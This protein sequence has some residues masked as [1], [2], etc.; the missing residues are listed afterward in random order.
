MSPSIASSP[1]QSVF[2][3][4]KGTPPPTNGGRPSA[5][6]G[7][8]HS[9]QSIVENAKQRPPSSASNK[10]NGHVAGTPDLST[11]ANITGRSI[12][13]VKASMKETG[14]NSKG[15][16]LLEDVQQEDPDMVGALV[17]G[18]R[19]DNAMKREGSET[20]GEHLGIQ[21]AN[22]VTTKSGR[23]SKPSTPAI[24]QFP[25]ATGRS[26]SSR[27]FVENTSNNKRSHKK[28]AGAAAQQQQ[29]LLAQHDD[30]GSSMQGDGDD[31]E[32]DVG[33]EPTYCFCN[34]VSYGEMVGCD[35]ENCEKEWFH[36]ECV[37][38]KVAPKGN[39]ESSF[40]TYP[41][42]QNRLKIKANRPHSQV[43]LQRLQRKNDQTLQ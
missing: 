29:Q 27:A 2:Q 5:A 11:A 35:S 18:N 16:H 3:D 20:N 19:K 32:E 4:I 43:V 9:T 25:E 14:T 23:A 36:L 12:S 21:T 40:S 41:F 30:D 10:P 33:N 7:R 37:G 39:C 24:P 6:R 13:E 42:C 8:Q 34:G 28:G 22:I 26:R 1:I 17:V 15:E 31:E 38:L